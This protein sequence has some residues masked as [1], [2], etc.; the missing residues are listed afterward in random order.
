MWKEK[1]KEIKKDEETDEEKGRKREAG[2]TWYKE[3]RRRGEQDGK[4]TEK[5][6]WEWNKKEREVEEKWKAEII[7]ERVFFTN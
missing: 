5:K 1:E 4:S 7:W 3:R 2:I 6:N